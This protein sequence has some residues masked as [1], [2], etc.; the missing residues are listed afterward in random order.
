MS[1][2]EILHI[3]E[4]V[5]VALM[6]SIAVT[7]LWLVLGR[8]WL[9][10]RMAVWLILIGSSS[11]SLAIGAESSNGKSW[12]P[13]VIF[14]YAAWLIASF[15]VIRWAGYRLEWQWRFGKPGAATTTTEDA[16]TVL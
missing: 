4:V 6:T 2:L 1:D 13:F 3:E 7:S 9:A 16:I 15:L 12:A 14:T 8:R 11:L 5:A 10:L